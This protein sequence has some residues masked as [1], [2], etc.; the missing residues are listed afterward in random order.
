MTVSLKSC[1]ILCATLPKCLL[2]F[3]SLYLPYTIYSRNVQNDET[4]NRISGPIFVHICRVAMRFSRFA[5][6]NPYIQ[7]YQFT[8]LMV[9]AIVLI[10]N[11]QL[12]LKIMAQMIL[13]IWNHSLL[14]YSDTYKQI[15][16]ATFISA[17][18]LY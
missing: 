12:V 13:S 5:R 6:I 8:V 10:C 7:Q 17:E 4:T 11:I 14:L 2:K 9:S 16:L 3:E 18:I 15:I 1:K